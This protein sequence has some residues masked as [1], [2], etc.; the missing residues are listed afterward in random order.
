MAR[1]RVVLRNCESY[2]ALTGES[3]K[4]NQ[5]RILTDEVQIALYRS[6]SEFVVSDLADPKRS[7]AAASTEDD[8]G[9]SGYTEAALKRMTKPELVELGAEK[10]SLAL[11]AEDAKGDLVAALLEAQ[12]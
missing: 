3:W 8:D 1:S 5:A 12:G 6:R 10:F 2:T 11:S 4:K 7:K 9:D